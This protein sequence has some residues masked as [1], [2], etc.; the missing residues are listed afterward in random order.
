M[1][2]IQYVVSLKSNVFIGIILSTTIWV[3]SV[4]H[5]NFLLPGNYLM[6]VRHELIQAD[7]AGVMTGVLWSVIILI[8]MFILGKHITK[9]KD[10]F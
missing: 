4:F 7:G 5:W 8:L 3:C 10:I 2:Y 1:A 9:Y 6:I